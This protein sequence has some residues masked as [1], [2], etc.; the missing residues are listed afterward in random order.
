MLKSVV[1]LSA[2]LVTVLGSAQT[3]PHAFS[4]T[5]VSVAGDAVTLQDQDGKVRVVQ[6]T[7]GWT[8]SVNRAVAADAIKAGSFVATQNI[9]LDASTG[10]STEVRILEPGYRP[11]QGTHAVS[12]T[13]SNMMTHGRVTHVS[14]SA[15]GVQLEVSYPNGSRRIIVPPGVAVTLSDPLSHSVLKPGVAVAGVSRADASGIDR[16][17]RLQLLPPH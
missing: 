13:N 1:C 14:A 8:V 11:E 16:A 17:S 5:L 7:P 6:M 4:G 3:P 2:L 9:P 12:A 15:D 10:K